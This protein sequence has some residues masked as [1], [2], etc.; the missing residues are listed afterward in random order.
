LSWRRFCRLRHRLQ[1]LGKL[2]IVRVKDLTDCNISDPDIK[3]L[4]PRVSRTFLPD[5][6]GAAAGVLFPLGRF[7]AQHTEIFEIVGHGEMA[8]PRSNVGSEPGKQGVLAA[9]GAQDIDGNAVF[10]LCR[11]M[12]DERITRGVAALVGEIAPAITLDKLADLL[13]SETDIDA[14]ADN[15]ELGA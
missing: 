9:F 2:L 7:S 13:G 12:R 14:L 3:G 4:V 1:A 11:P 8:M 5:N 10:A 6:D 15:P